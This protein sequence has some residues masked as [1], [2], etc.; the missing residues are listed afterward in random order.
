MKKAVRVCRLLA[1]FTVFLSCDLNPPSNRPPEEPSDVFTAIPVASDPVPEY[2]FEPEELI[3]SP[4]SSS[5]LTPPRPY[6]SPP[7]D[8]YQW[9][10]NYRLE[11]FS[12]K[13]EP[14]MEERFGGKLGIKKA[15]LWDHNSYNSHAVGFAVSLPAISVVEYGETA[16]YGSHT[17]VSESYFYNHLFYLKDLKEG[18]AYHYRVIVQDEDGNTIALPDRTFTTKTFTGEIKQLYQGDFTHE[19][20]R[21]GLWITSPGIHVLMEDIS[22]DGLGINIKAHDVTI[23]LNGH[24]LTYDNGF[25]PFNDT[26][27]GYNESASYGIRAGLWNFT[28]A[29]IYNGI[30]KQGKTGS[31]GRE[32]LFLLHMGNTGATKNEVAGLT[33]DYYGDD[34]SGMRTGVGYV[35]HNLLYDRGSKVTDRH[36]GVRAL[37]A[38]HNSATEV[39]YNSL[40]R[41]RQN[42]ITNAD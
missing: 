41:F 13:T 29:R 17:E 19:G 39:A 15:S 40:R 20:G 16:A 11:H 23:D 32:P 38:D 25:N 37:L 3:G 1:V 4:A 27:N 21:S 33:V 10:F 2:A 22:A 34:S 36:G 14:L 6:P 31:S 28:N 30:I 5:Y 18:T 42:G 26:N 7:V 8:S 9:F 35:H 24:T 12:P